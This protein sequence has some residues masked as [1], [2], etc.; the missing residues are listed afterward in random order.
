MLNFLA[1]VFAEPMMHFLL[2]G[3]LLFA[4]MD[5][6]DSGSAWVDPYEISVNQTSLIKFLQFRNKSFNEKKAKEKWLAMPSVEKNRLVDDYVRQEVMYREALNLGLDEEDQIIRR[7][8]IQKIEF[9]NRGFNSDL[10]AIDEMEIEAYFSKN[11]ADFNIDAA[12]T[13][14]HVFIEKQSNGMDSQ[15]K[16]RTILEK[17]NDNAVPLEDAP[18]YG[19]RFLFHRNYVDRTFELVDSHFGA[20]FAKQVFALPSDQKHWYGPYQSQ[21]GSHLVMVNKNQPQRLPRLE[22]VAGQ[23]LQKV[24]RVKQDELKRHSL[25]KMLKK[26]SLNWEVELDHTLNVTTQSKENTLAWS[27]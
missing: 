15:E 17:L 4:F 10:A 7:R 19:D 11:I 2:L 24:R 5:A 26:Y 14:S 22:E 27:N 20:E 23:V 12:I 3:G 8:L 18:G 16:A 21:Y 6:V 9:I 13:F 1:K 25:D